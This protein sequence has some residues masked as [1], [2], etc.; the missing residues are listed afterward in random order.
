MGGVVGVPAR[1]WIHR[2]HQ[3]ETR[4]EITGRRGS[5]DRDVPIFKWLT[6]HLQHVA[7]EFR[8]LVQEEHAAVRERDLPRLRVRATT[9]QS[10]VAHRV[11]RRTKWTSRHQRNAALE[12][13][14]HGMDARHLQSLL[15]GERRKNGW[16]APR[17]HRLA[18]AR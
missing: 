17:E 1:A 6:H 5:G 4:G 13:S 15:W 10:T 16:N 14:R 12:L 18:R 11:V 8:E 2:R 3:H 7:A 9:E